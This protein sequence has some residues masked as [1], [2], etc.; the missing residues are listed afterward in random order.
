[1]AMRSIVKSDGNGSTIIGY[2]PHTLGIG[3]LITLIIF[4]TTVIYAAGGKNNKIEEHE[5]KIKMMEDCMSKLE[6]KT[7]KLNI[8]VSLLCQKEGIQIPPD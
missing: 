5:K 4:V 1:M 7:T 6:S 2:K 8:M 3:A